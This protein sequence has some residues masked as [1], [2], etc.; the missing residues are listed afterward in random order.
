MI[1]SH[2]FGLRIYSQKLNRSIN[3]KEIINR[4]KKNIKFIETKI[5]ADYA[6][7]QINSSNFTI[8]NNFYKLD[9]QYMYF[10]YEAQKL[11]DFRHKSKTY[12]LFDLKLIS[13]II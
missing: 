2:K 13:K 3:H 5:L 8:Q 9:N 6:E 10:R 1:S 12:N 7:E 4:L 11:L